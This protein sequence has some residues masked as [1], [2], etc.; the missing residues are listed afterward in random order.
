M[1]N[2][3]SEELDNLIRVITAIQTEEDCL[4]FQED[5]CTIKEIEEL[6]KRMCGAKMLS[7]NKIYTEITETTG[8]STATISRINRSLRYGTDGYNTVLERLGDLPSPYDN[9]TPDEAEKEDM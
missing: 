1:Q 3:H 2:Y 5:L 9:D 8:L 4:A 6:A 7:D